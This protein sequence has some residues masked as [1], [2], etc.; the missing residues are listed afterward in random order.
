VNA[1]VPKPL[2]LLTAK[3]LMLTMGIAFV[4][5][6]AVNLHVADY[7]YNP[8]AFVYLCPQKVIALFVSLFI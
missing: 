5:S 2:S 7:S 6:R 3:E 8:D 4:G 1:I